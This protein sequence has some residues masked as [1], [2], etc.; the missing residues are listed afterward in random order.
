M[1][2]VILAEGHLGS[3]QKQNN[4]ELILDLVKIKNTFF[5]I[6]KVILSSR[7]FKFNF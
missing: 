7:V 5:L 3:I 6:K 2:V 1:R 4:L